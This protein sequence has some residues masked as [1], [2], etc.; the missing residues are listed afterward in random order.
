MPQLILLVPFW[1]PHVRFY[2][3]MMIVSDGRIFKYTELYNIND[4][5]IYIYIISEKAGTML[6]LQ[7]TIF[8]R[9]AHCRNLLGVLMLSP[10]LF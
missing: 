10:I 5:F 4:L 6:V 2:E 3:A 8:C 7:T 1:S 9:S